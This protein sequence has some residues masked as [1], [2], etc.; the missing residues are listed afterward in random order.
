MPQLD[1]TIIFS[2]IFW[3]F[4][5]FTS[6]YTI[7]THFFLPK[8]LRSL[9]ARKHISDINILE[10]SNVVKRTADKQ[11]LLKKILLK[12]LLLVRQTFSNVNLFSSINNKN[13][14]ICELDKKI[15]N[16]IYNT[17]LYCDYSLLESISLYPKGLNLK[18]KNN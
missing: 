15:S 13:I 2:Q 16:V 7:L 1:Q 14:D 10:T 9:K 8:F 18:F 5:I 11:V 3:L 6:L 17:T 12:N 4:L